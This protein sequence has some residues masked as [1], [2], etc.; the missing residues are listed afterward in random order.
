MSSKPAFI[1]SLIG[2][3][4]I[5]IIGS[6]ALADDDPLKTQTAESVENSDDNYFPEMPAETEDDEVDNIARLTRALGNSLPEKAATSSFAT[7]AIIGRLDGWPA[8]VP[9]KVCFR[10]GAPDLQRAVAQTA[11]A[12]NFAGTPLPLDF[13]TLAAPRQCPASVSDIS[14]KLVDGISQS[15]L[16]IASQNG[17]MKLGVVGI[18]PL[19]SKFKQIVL[20]EFGHA[21]GLRHEMKHADADCWNEFKLSELKALYSA[22]FNITEE[23][24]MR[25]EVGAFDP[26][27]MNKTLFSPGYDKTSV[28]MYAFPTT[29]YVQGDKSRCWAPT[30]DHL[31]TRDMETLKL[32]YQGSIIIASRL[33][34]LTAG[35][36]ADTKKLANAFNSLILAHPADRP[37]LVR[38]A[39]ALP[40]DAAPGAIADAV[41][42]RSQQLSVKNWGAR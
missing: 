22:K 25:L 14:I 20:H 6:P 38:A 7:Y 28:M 39:E 31:S 3:F 30:A 35:E 41:L 40:K 21:L 24:K 19:S 32:A 36:S 11:S 27:Q 16:G 37:A 4:S 23:A 33:A 29:V 8:H 26:A 5:G 42:S 9:I 12:W 10:D 15:P 34:A 2:S 17:I 13:G 18:D 1:I